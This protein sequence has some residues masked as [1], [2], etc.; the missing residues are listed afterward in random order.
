MAKIGSA[1]RE[2]L[3][4]QQRPGA[5]PAPPPAVLTAREYVAFATFAARFSPAPKAK[6]TFGGRH[7]KL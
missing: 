7:W 5:M 4:A 1:E 3:R 6:P 2:Q